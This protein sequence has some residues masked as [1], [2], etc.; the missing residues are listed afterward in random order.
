MVGRGKV[1]LDPNI[2]KHILDLDGFDAP[3]CAHIRGA[4]RMAKAHEVL[5]DM[6]SSV[7]M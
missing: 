2:F 3:F 4:C 7:H 6:E 1:G 5:A